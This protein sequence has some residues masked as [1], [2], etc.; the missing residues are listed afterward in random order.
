MLIPM[1]VLLV[2]IIVGVFG[3]A[4]H[5][6][7]LDDVDQEALRILSDESNDLDAVIDGDQVQSPLA[8]QK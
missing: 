1:S 8:R 7:Q 2:L 6:G 4:V 5:N 3:W